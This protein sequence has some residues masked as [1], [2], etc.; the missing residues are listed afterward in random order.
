MLST[1]LVVEIEA[2]PA[3]S[4]V[5]VSA[6]VGAALVSKLT[7][8]TVMVLGDAVVPMVNEMVAVTP[9]AAAKLLDSTM[10]GEVSAPLKM[11]GNDTKVLPSMTTF[12]ELNV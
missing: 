9:V 5:Q 3:L 8:A 1:R 10:E 7:P 11:A 2:V 6:E 4:P 12:A